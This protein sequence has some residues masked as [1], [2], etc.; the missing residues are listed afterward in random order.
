[1]MATGHMDAGKEKLGFRESRKMTVK[2]ISPAHIGSREGRISALEFVVSG[3]RVHL[4]DESKFADYLLKKNLID[5]FV[6]E[7]RTGPIQME[8]FLREKGKMSIPAQL[9]SVV[10]QTILGGSPRMQDFRPLVRDGKGQIY[11]P[12]STL[13]GVFRT[14]VLYR[15]L[16][17]DEDVRKKI[18]ARTNENTREMKRRRVSYSQRWLQE[19]HLQSFPLPKGRRGP[20]EDILRCLT[21][22]D[23]YPVGAVETKVIPIRFLS[24]SGDGQHYWSQ[25]KDRQGRPTGGDLLLWL[26]AITAGTFEIELLWDNWVFSQFQKFSVTHSL[27]ILGLDDLIS[28]LQEMMSDL[29][30]HEKAFFKMPPD[31][32][33]KP[34]VKTAVSNINSFYSRIDGDLI[35]FGFGSG[36]LSTTVNLSLPTELRQ[37][38]RDICGSAPRPGDPAPKSRRLWA[39]DDG[40]CFPLGWLSTQMPSASKQ[41]TESTKS[42]DIDLSALEKKFRVRRS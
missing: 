16:K 17:R 4:I 34:E 24:L 39:R 12:G 28:A 29:I 15:I 30:E 20:N 38:I 2:V 1:M 5:L 18:I 19:D 25:R 10:S 40:T 8:R 27:P 36:M 41:E 35:R 31:P 23:A 32:R 37:T 3:G 14:A 21:I 42:T 9:Q 26:E 11:L 33:T 22:R 6:E 7:A 13:K